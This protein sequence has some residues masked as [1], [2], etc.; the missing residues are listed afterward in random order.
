[1]PRLSFHSAGIVGEKMILAIGRMPVFRRWIDCFG[2]V[3]LQQTG[4][5]TKRKWSV[6]TLGILRPIMRIR[7]R[8]ADLLSTEY[9]NGRR[10]SRCRL[11]PP[12]E[13]DSKPLVRHSSDKSSVALRTL[14]KKV[15]VFDTGMHWMKQLFDATR[16]ITPLVQDCDCETCCAFGN[17]SIIASFRLLWQNGSLLS[18]RQAPPSPEIEGHPP[19]RGRSWTVH[20]SCGD[21]GSNR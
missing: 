19:G 14:G 2:R 16:S 7:V 21:S 15:T 1:M 17:S 18:L 10:R 6:R 3:D 20:H 9:V 4:Y 5:I 12:N 8:L 11:K 13:L